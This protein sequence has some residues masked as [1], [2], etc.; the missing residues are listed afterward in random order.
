[1]VR[2][3]AKRLGYVASNRGRH[4]ILDDEALAILAYV[5]YRYRL[6]TYSDAVKLMK[7]LIE[8]CSEKRI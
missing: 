7:T 6:K 2:S 8:K 1:M 3:V 4:I 5:K